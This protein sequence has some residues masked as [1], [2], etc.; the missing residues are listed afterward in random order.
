MLNKE[1]LSAAAMGLTFSMFFPYIRF[2]FK[3]LAVWRIGR[4][5]MKSAKYK[6]VTYDQIKI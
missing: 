2:Q 1:F 3:V 5:G 4:L 6:T